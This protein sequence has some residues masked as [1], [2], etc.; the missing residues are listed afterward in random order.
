MLKSELWPR[1]DL[2]SRALDIAA[3]EVHCDDVIAFDP[4]DVTK[5]YAK[6]MDYLYPV[7][8]GSTGKIGLGWEDFGVEA[9]RWE[10]GRKTHTP[11][12]EKLSNASCPD[13]VSQNQQIIIAIRSVYEQ[14]DEWCGV[15]AFDRL[16]DRTILF[17]FLLS[18][19][20]FWIVRMKFNRG[21]RFV[22][23]EAK[24]KVEDLVGMLPLSKEA[25]WL[26]FPKRSGEL[27]VAW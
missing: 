26:L 9:I 13:Y 21:L 3:R 1:E 22:D 18:L 10:N 14:L 5:K 16:H 19:K 17:K 12:Y 11:L 4:G 6:K 25:W 2:R 23:G 7:H 27:H 24:V 20:M 8:D 15:W